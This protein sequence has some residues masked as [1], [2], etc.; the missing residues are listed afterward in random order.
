[1]HTLNTNLHRLLSKTTES[2]LLISE[3]R[4]KVSRLSYD[5]RRQ[6]NYGSMACKT[7][8][9]FLDMEIHSE[10]LDPRI[11]KSHIFIL[12]DL[13]NEDAYAILEYLKKNPAYPI[14]II[15]DSTPQ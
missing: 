1:M 2:D 6:L 8:S 3:I 9:N 14:I 10:E 15:N 13:D 4:N 11:K 12:Q 7:L 5:H